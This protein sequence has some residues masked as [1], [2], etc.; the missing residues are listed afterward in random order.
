METGADLQ[1][2]ICCVPYHLKS[3]LYSTRFNIL[4]GDL[5]Y[6]IIIRYLL[7]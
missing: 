6:H 4:L 5:P 1:K 7:L 3:L 2:V